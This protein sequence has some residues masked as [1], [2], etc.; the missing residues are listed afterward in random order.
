MRT[1]VMYTEKADHNNNNNNKNNNNNN[2]L[3]S[4]FDLFKTIII[5][6]RFFLH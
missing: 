6:D 1:N 2:T 3:K 4:C 5:Q